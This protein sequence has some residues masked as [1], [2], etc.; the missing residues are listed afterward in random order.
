MQRRTTA[1]LALASALLV[2]L[3]AVAPVGSSSSSGDLRAAPGAGCTAAER[4]PPR[5]LRVGLVLDAGLTNPFDAI[6]FRGLQRAVREL[7]V[8]GKAL[9]MGPKEGAL[10]SL[11]YLA[12]QRFDL[13]ATSGGLYGDALDAAALQFPGVCFLSLDGPRSM[14]AHRPRN[15]R[16]TLY[17]SEEASYL[18]GYL[19]VLVAKRQ[20]GRPVV[21][22]VGGARIP[23]VDRF[24]A[25]FRAGAR[26]ADPDVRLLGGY[27]QEFGDEKKCRAL[28]LH[29]IA[30]GSRVVFQVAGTCGLGALQAAKE[31]H[32]WGIGV[33]ADESYLGPHV[34]TSVLKNMDVALVREVRS[35]LAGTFRTSSTDVLTLANGGVGL[36][37]ISPRVP[38]ALVAKLER[39]RREVIAGRIAVPA[40]LR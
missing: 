24:I 5:K 35:L 32:V 28:A 9:V 33:D 14:L 4:L 11:S 21:S 29:Q 34:L 36:G 38:R 19:A 12:R 40:T 31:K 25:G 18:A 27:T 13:I 22:T 6:M 23:Q 20:P 10:A 39:V 3:L 15:L 1:A 7:G 8:E 2:A 17:R 37:T 16:E 30:E 26:R